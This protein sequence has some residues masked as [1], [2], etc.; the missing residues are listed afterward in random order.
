MNLELKKYLD[1]WVGN[2]LLFP[3][4]WRLRSNTSAIRPFAEALGIF[5]EYVV[6][7]ET[8]EVF[9]SWIVERHQNGSTF[10]W[11]LCR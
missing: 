1:F 5:D 2:L 11:R 10:R 8:D 4:C 3:H 9:D 6:I 7:N